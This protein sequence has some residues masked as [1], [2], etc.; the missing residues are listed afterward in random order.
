MR[1]RNIA[2]KPMV[3]VKMKSWYVINPKGG[4]KRRKQTGN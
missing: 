2:I 4:T 1:Q 3:R